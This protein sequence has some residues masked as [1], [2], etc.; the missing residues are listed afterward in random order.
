[1]LEKGFK[2][3]VTVRSLKNSKHSHLQHENLKIFEVDILKE[4]SF[5]EAFKDA[6]AVVHCASPFKLTSTNPKEEII[7][8]AIEGTRNVILACKG[9]KTIKKLVLIS[10]AAVIK[11]KKK[12]YIYTENDWNEEILEKEAYPYSKLQSEKLAWDM[13]KSKDIDCEL[14]VLNPGFV[15]GPSVEKK[16]DS[17]SFKTIQG[18]IDGETKKLH[19]RPLNVIDVRDVAMAVLNSIQLQD[20]GM[21]R[22][23]L[24]SEKSITLNDICLVLKE[25]FKNLKLPNTL[26][27]KN[28]E[29]ILFD[30]SRSRKLLKLEYTDWKKSII[31][32]AK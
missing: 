16:S 11:G 2:V 28:N 5:N 23:I 24:A 18:I 32:M 6:I 7:K 29:I 8:P 13:F 30:N 17:V 9:S 14:V 19:N 4:G 20:V 3:N 21:N 26:D 12:D 15:I 27:N 10:S 25:N 31:D 22:F 1:M